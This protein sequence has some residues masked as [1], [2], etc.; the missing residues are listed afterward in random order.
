LKNKLFHPCFIKG[1]GS[2]AR[3]TDF[4]NIAQFR[5]YIRGA[6]EKNRNKGQ[7]PYGANRNQP[8]NSTSV[9]QKMQRFFHEADPK[10]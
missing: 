4:S 9:N 1:E 8:A 5:L 6:I 2:I 10:I 7:Q 3:A